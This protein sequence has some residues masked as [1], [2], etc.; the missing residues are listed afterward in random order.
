MDHNLGRIDLI[1]WQTPR[2]RRMKLGVT[3]WT[4]ILAASAMV[5]L[6]LIAAQ[7]AGWVH[8]DGPIAAVPSMLVLLVVGAKLIEGVRALL[9]WLGG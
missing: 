8:I 7:T 6:P 4:V 3:P 1:T 5:G 2:N 9:S